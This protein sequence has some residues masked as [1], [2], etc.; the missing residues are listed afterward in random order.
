MRLTLDIDRCGR[1]KSEGIWRLLRFLFPKHRI[2][3]RI[4]ASGKGRHFIVYGVSHDWSE[5]CQLR[6]WL[7]DDPKRIVIDD[8]VRH[9]AGVQTQILFTYKRGKK[10]QLI[11]WADDEKKNAEGLLVS[12]RM[13]QPPT[14]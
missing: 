7:G 14:P 8:I 10:A 11:R 3:E 13:C 1:R 9:A 4:S 2:V 12:P 6:R 5:I